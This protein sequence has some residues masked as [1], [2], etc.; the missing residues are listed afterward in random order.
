MPPTHKTLK[1]SGISIARIA[2]GKI[3]EGWQNWDMLGLME[4]IHGS[5]KSPT[6]A[7]AAG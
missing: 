4:Q 5:A 6:Y 7:A 3:V 1:T 2:D